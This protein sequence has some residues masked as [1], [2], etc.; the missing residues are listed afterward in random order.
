MMSDRNRL[1]GVG[2]G[3]TR[4]YKVEDGQAIT[5]PS[6]LSG[7]PPVQF[8][9]GAPPYHDAESTPIA[10][11]PLSHIS[12][13]AGSAIS[14]LTVFAQGVNTVSVTPFGKTLHRDT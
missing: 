4:F 11:R 10:Q 12:D 9:P 7:G 2:H 6:L 13:S 14:A 5:S 3:P 8:W 1:F